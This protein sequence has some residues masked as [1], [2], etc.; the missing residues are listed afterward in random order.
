MQ[1][2][3]IFFHSLTPLLNI[4]D[5]SSFWVAESM[6]DKYF[7]WLYIQNN[8]IVWVLF[9]F[10]FFSVA[11]LTARIRNYQ[12]H[13]QKHHKVS[14]SRFPAVCLE[15]ELLV[16]PPVVQLWH[17]RFYGLLTRTIKVSCLP[18]F[19]VRRVLADFLYTPL[20]YKKTRINISKFGS[21]HVA[22]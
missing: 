18:S 1:T 21:F 5:L 19:S 20:H 12:E 16:W 6:T 3:S 10:F 17:H 8:I 2:F 9:V 13:L 11:I 7:Y 14:H 4:T 15:D 22:L